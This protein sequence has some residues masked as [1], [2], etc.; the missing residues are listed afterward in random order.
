MLECF[1]ALRSF[2]HLYSKKLYSLYCSTATNRGPGSLVGI[3]RPI[4]IGFC[5]TRYDYFWIATTGSG[6]SCDYSEFHHGSCC[7]ASGVAVPAGATAP[8][9]SG[10]ATANETPA[11]SA[12]HSIV[13]P[14]MRTAMALL[15]TGV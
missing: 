12:V 7:V 1:P 11:T 3:G 8:G 10:A 2:S 5:A 15:L 4:R 14:G 13:G 9:G 6:E